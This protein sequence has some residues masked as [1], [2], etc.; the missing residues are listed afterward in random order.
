VRPDPD[1][2]PLPP[3]EVDRLVEELKKDVDRTLIRENLKL[4][5]EERL[6]QL[7]RFQEFAE[8]LGRAG[9]KTFG[10]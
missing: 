10:R 7:T 6:V 1:A 2:L 8:E 3:I 9:R 5:V 4:T